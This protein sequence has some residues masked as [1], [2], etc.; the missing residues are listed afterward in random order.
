MIGA[1]TTRQRDT[2]FDFWMHRPLLH[3]I[4]YYI[5][6]K[7]YKY[8]PKSCSVLDLT[9][10]N[11]TKLSTQSVLKTSPREKAP[12]CSFSD[13]ISFSGMVA[14]DGIHAHSC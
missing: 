4:L 5:S 14:Q 7:S 2:V 1:R 6:S 9:S 12:S 11:L 13:F 8:L 3:V 10:Y